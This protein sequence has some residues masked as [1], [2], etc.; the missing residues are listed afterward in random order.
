MLKTVIIFFFK[1]MVME[2]GSEL[3]KCY[4]WDIL[5]DMK[6]AVIHFQLSF[7]VRVDCFV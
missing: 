1:K 7:H 3:I 4:C 2:G 5:K 6:F